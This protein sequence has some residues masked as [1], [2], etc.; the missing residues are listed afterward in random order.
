MKRNGEKTDRK[1]KHPG[2]F[3][4]KLRRT[5]GSEEAPDDQHRYVGSPII[6]VAPV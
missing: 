4:T 2:Q 1:V 5:E 6:Y 3:N